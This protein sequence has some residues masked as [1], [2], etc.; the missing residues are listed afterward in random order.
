[1]ERA[2]Y[3]LFVC[4]LPPLGK[5]F[6][7][8]LQ[9]WASQNWRKKNS[10]RRLAARP[11][12]IGK[13]LS[14]R[15]SQRWR[16]LV[17]AA[18]LHLLFGFLNC[19]IRSQ[20]SAPHR[21]AM[22]LPSLIT[23]MLKTVVQISVKK[24]LS[25][26]PRVLF[27]VTRLSTRFLWRFSKCWSMNFSAR[28]AFLQKPQCHSLISKWI[29]CCSCSRN[30]SLSGRSLHLLGSSYFSFSTKGIKYSSIA[31]QAARLLS[32][33]QC[34]SCASGFVWRRILESSK[35]EEDN[36]PCLKLYVEI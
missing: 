4:F 35:I 24:E 2:R 11:W 26:N 27:Q 30:M 29:L 5:G 7:P 1:M 16:F 15:L 10:W 8:L 31:S 22:H 32:L 28:K 33:E 13:Q 9:V 21:S 20:C 12:L 34:T 14:A 25:S 3:N 23:R 6:V 36:S 19:I 18:A 17:A